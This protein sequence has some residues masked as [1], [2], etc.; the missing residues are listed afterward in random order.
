M[1]WDWF[2]PFPP[3]SGPN[4]VLFDC[5]PRP[6][7]SWPSYHSRHRTKLS[8]RRRESQFLSSLVLSLRP[9]SPPGPRGGGE[10]QKV[11]VP[12]KIDKTPRR[13]RPCNAGEEDPIR[14]MTTTTMKNACRDWDLHC[15]HFSSRGPQVQEHTGHR[16]CTNIILLDTNHWRWWQ[17][18]LPWHRR[19]GHRRDIPPEVPFWCSFT[20]GVPVGWRS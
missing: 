20:G 5:W 11:L 15:A 2:S 1:S 14:M 13:P 18:L 9:P 3:L 17:Q 10:E 4:Q 8:C 7:T 16:N 6:F 19:R 12:H